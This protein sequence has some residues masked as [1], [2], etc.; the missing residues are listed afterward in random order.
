MYGLGLG[1]ILGW[2]HT[3]WAQAGSHTVW[4][5][6]GPILYGLGLGPILYG[7]RLGPCNTIPFIFQE[8]VKEMVAADI[9]LLRK[10]PTA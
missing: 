8:L 6:A 1:P 5:G 7:Q 4:T 3:I 10:D 9:E 2:S